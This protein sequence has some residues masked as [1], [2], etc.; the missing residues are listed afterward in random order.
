MKK[1]ELLTLSVVVIS[2]ASAF[3]A[4]AAQKGMGPVGTQLTSGECTGLGGK[5]AT[6]NLCNG[7]TS[8]VT[9][10]QNGVVHEVCISAKKAAPARIAP[11]RITPSTP[12]VKSQ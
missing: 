3:D 10:D 6:S 7:G 5:V 1:I 9:V 4:A 8:C 2:F 11:S 12:A